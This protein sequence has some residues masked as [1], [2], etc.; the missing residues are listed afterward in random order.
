MS[1]DNRS[2][3][4]RAAV[5]AL[6]GVLTLATPALAQGTADMKKVQPPP[7]GPAKDFKLPPV[8]EKSLSNGLRVIFIASKAQPV[9]SMTV[10]LK[11]GASVEPDDRAGLA[12]MTAGLV[13]QGTATRSAQ[14][15]AEAIDGAGGS[16]G[17]SAGWDSSS[18][19]TTVLVNRA[20]LAA[21]LLADVIMNPKFADEEI[22]RARTQT[23]SG[24][25]VARSSAGSVANEVFDR[26][27]FGKAPY[28]RPI[29]GTADTVNAIKR[30]DIVAFHKAQYVASNATLAIVGAVTAEEAFALAEKHFGAWAKGTAPVVAAGPASVAGKRRVIIL[31]KPDAA[32]TEIRVGLTGLSR[33]DADFY[34]ASVANSIF[35]GAPFSSRVESELRVKRGLTYGARSRLDARRNGGSFLI[36]TNTKTATTVEAVEVIFSEI[37]RMRT[38]D[39]PA[40]ELKARQGFLA[41]IFLLGLETPEAVASRLLQAELFGLGADY[42]ETYTSKVNAVSGAQVRAIAE[43]VINPDQ[44]VIVLAGNAK[45]FEAGVAKFGPVEKIP[46]EEVDVMSAD[47]RRPKAAVAAVSDTD[48]KAGEELARKT[49]AAVGGAAWLGQKTLV[50]KGKGKISPGPQTLDIT[51]VES[52]EI[53]PDRQRTELDLGIVK[54]K[55]WSN[56]EGSWVD[57][58]GGPQDISAQSKEG[59]FFGVKVLRRFGQGEKLT[60]RPLADGEV[61]GVKTKAFAVTDADG[62]TTEFHVDA[63]TSMPVKIAYTTSQ[64][65]IEVQTSDWR[66]VGGLKMPFMTV[67]FRNGQKFLEIML[68]EAQVNVEVDPALFAKP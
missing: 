43:R 24:L 57:Q 15:I 54:V 26:V 64:G 31:D 19:S 39:V 28:G 22:D 18:A 5:S 23:L 20:A 27:T 6:A 65:T 8:Q 34:R 50:A 14:Q 38:T 40:E 3:G 45:E 13:D 17:V 37:D 68:T 48:A 29:G 36:D 2:L 67:Q 47:L 9:V 59:K 66:E 33:G 46:F 51:S 32:Q 35:G 4:A 41:G 1:R 42:L 10:M 60:I 58:G 21:E 56:A 61:N 63:V 62:H 12:Q 11:T 25:Q 55:Q 44:M 52:W 16:L 7:V 49:I 30:D 53:L